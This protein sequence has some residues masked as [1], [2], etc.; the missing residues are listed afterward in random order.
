MIRMKCEECGNEGLSILHTVDVE[1]EVKF[2][3]V[4]IPPDDPE[5]EGDG[6]NPQ[7]VEKMWYGKKD[8]I[9]TS[10]KLKKRDSTKKE[11][12]E[13]CGKRHY[14]DNL[15]SCKKCGWETCQEPVEICIYEGLEHIPNL[16]DDFMEE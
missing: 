6:F 10:M 13:G 2:T 14:V 5:Y 1:L 11:I 3:L 12:E 15:F 8:I 9:W 16:D 4:H 7:V